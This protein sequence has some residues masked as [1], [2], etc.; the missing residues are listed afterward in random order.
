MN[1][2]LAST[3]HNW[4]VLYIFKQVITAIIYNIYFMLLAYSM[5]IKQV[6]RRSLSALAPLSLT[7]QVCHQ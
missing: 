2:Y 7:T 4:F 3:T 5:W 1:I 6:C